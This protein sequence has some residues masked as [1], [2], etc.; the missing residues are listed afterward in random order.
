MN[1]KTRITIASTTIPGA[2]FTILRMSDGRR[3]ALR[4]AAAPFL[5][6]VRLAVA[7][8]ET[9]ENDENP[10]SKA[11]VRELRDRVNLATDAVNREWLRLG[12]VS[13]EGFTIDDEPVTLGNLLSDG[14]EDFRTEVADAIKKAATLSGAEEGEFGPLS[15]SDAPVD[16]R[17]NDSSAEPAENKASS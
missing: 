11:Q 5:H 2:S 17:M 16:G 6:E 8:I 12:L 7:E 13:V 1:Y 14:P 9:L 10:H 4:E 3:A 15:I